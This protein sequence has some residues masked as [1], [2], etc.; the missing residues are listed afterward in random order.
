MNAI[1]SIP[2]DAIIFHHNQIRTNSI[3]V[4]EAFGKLHKNVIRKLESLECSPE[5]TQL[6]FEPS[7]FQDST[8]RKLPMWEMTKDGFMFLVMGFTGKKAAQIKEAFINAFNAMAAEL[9][10]KQEAKKLPQPLTPA[11][12]RHIQAR[13]SYLA[14]QPGSSFQ[15]VWR[16]VK[17][18]FNVGTY[19]DIPCTRFN[20]L[21]KYLGA[22]IKVLEG[23]YL[24]GGQLELAPVLNIN[25]PATGQHHLYAFND[26]HNCGW[27][28]DLSKFLVILE[29][30]AGKNITLSIEDVSKLRK[31]LISLQ[32]LTEVYRNRLEDIRSSALYMVERAHT[33]KS[34][35]SID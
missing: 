29:R 12:Q 18:R 7:E 20:E 32:H 25:F 3:K 9:S 30:N 35:G 19:K 15:S 21:C 34:V 2:Q 24:E 23:E 17:D 27:N 22:P 6:N 16:S 14:T 31:E 5:F 28:T 13:V 4:S 11:M 8:G 10:K 1:A 26:L 33:R